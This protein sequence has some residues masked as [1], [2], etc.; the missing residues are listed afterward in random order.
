MAI[1]TCS[2]PEP[3]KR[4]IAYC[5]VCNKPLYKG[6]KVYENEISLEELIDHYCSMDCLLKEF[7]I[8]IITL[9]EE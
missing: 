5:E 2:S 9:G 6:D 4:V 3:S 1:I 8:E 7:E